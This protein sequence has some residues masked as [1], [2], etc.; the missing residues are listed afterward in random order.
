M[1]CGAAKLTEG[2]LRP[3]TRMTCAVW[4]FPDVFP[5]WGRKQGCLDRQETEVFLSLINSPGTL[6]RHSS[7][8]N[9]PHFVP[10]LVFLTSERHIVPF[11]DIT[12]LCVCEPFYLTSLKQSFQKFFSETLVDDWWE[13]TLWNPYCWHL[14][15][16]RATLHHFK[17]KKIAGNLSAGFEDIDLYCSDKHRN[18]TYSELKFWCLVHEV[19]MQYLDT[20]I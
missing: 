1:C 4:V 16:W 12:R 19:F 10:R 2:T 5:Y 6:T 20:K 9:V 13:H 11:Y 14:L 3:S 8:W 18:H 15:Q 7:L 17:L